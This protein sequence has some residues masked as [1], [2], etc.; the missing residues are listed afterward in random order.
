M[1]PW[2]LWWQR[3]LNYPLSGNVNQDFQYLSP[4]YE[5][6]FAGNKEI[7]R[8]AICE[9]ASYGK[10][11]GILSDVLIELCD[12]QKHHSETTEKLH[13][14]VKEI[15]NIKERHYQV[16]GR[17]IKQQLEWLKEHNRAA[18][19]DLLNELNHEEAKAI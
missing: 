17:K 9:V 3:T 16:N 15:N 5:F 12:K 19:D 10:Q 4:T 7:E 1:H 8:K 14:M 11:L 13:L 2:Y 6:N 18:F